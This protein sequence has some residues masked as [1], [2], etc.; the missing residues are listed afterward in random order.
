MSLIAVPFMT[1]HLGV[2]DYGRFVTVSSIIFIIGGVTEAGLTNLGTR[3]FAVL[4]P[5]QREHFLRNLAGLRFTL[6]TAGVVF[7][8]LFT[9]VTGADAVIVE[10]TLIAGVGLLLTLTQATYAIPLTAELRLGWVAGL[11][12]V[13]QGVLTVGILALVAAGAGLLPFFATSVVSGFVVLVLTLVVARQQ[14]A[15]RP[16]AEMATWRRVMRDVLPYALATAVGLIYFRLAVILMSY[17]STSFE[18]GIYS[19]AFRI[20]EVVAV[21]PWLVVSSAFPILARAARD[22]E[23]RLRYALQRLFEVSTALGAGIAL[24]L[25]LGASFAVDVIGGLPE[26]EGSVPVL[27][28]LAVALVTQ[29][30]VATWSFALLS[31]RAHRELLVANGIAALVAA[32]GTIALSSWQGAKGAAIAT[33][34]SEAVLAIVYFVA[35][36]RRRAA[37]T[38]ALGMVWKVLVA[39]AAGGLAALLPVP[40]VVKA[41]IGGLVYAAV[42]VALRG[43]PPELLHALR[44]R[45]PDPAP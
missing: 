16:L 2:S 7:A 12:L 22:D 44:G 45:D 19:T 33:V 20:V 18:T 38:P 43:L 34:G 36:R 17:V 10:G 29:F 6:T 40:S 26:F 1:R 42:I 25:A 4:E 23:G 28:L 24:V 5:G 39:A 41:A 8:G 11:E 31:L 9:L 30:L 27:Q 32:A 13:R 14:S 37:L 15:V 21:I 3:E 35:L